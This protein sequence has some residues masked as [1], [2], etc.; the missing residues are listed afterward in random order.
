METHFKKIEFLKTRNFIILGIVLLIGIFCGK[1]AL[2][3]EI[4]I[5]DGESQV[6]VE[7]LFSNVE[8]AITKANIKLNEHDQVTVPLKSKVEAGMIAF[9]K[10]AYP[11][12]IE[13]DG[14]LIEVMTANEKTGEI[15]KEYAISIGNQDRTEPTADEKVSKYETIKVVRVKEK[16]VTQKEDIPFERMIQ[17]NYKLDK[18][19][20]NVI[21][22][23]ENGEREAKYKVVYEDGKEV[24]KELIEEKVLKSP[25]EELIEEG[26]AMMVATSRGNIRAKKAIK[27]TATAYDISFESCG[28]YPGDKNYGITRSG[29]KV[30]PGVVAVDPKVIPLG[31]K[32]YIKSTD[33]SKD[34]GIA[35][36][37]DIG[38]AIKGNRIDLY[39]ESPKDVKKYGRRKVLVY[40]LK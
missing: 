29:T 27:M 18:G 20:I 37:E 26:T 7:V 22:K 38:G 2:T 13:V 1:F 33:G 11:V 3:K 12:N 14:K 34:Y 32:L 35:S 9:I 28:K 19:K 39:F 25:Q 8:D 40:I 15:L 23:G 21:K 24:E 31:S 16:I 17:Y 36:A 30:R 5:K 10:R 6:K 4:I